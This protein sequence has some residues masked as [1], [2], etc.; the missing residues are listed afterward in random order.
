MMM[1]S[2]MQEKRLRSLN[3]NKWRRLNPQM[4]TKSDCC[5]DLIH[6]LYYIHIMS[7]VIKLFFFLLQLRFL[8]GLLRLDLCLLHSI[9]SFFL[10]LFHVFLAEMQ[11]N[12]IIFNFCTTNFASGFFLLL[13]FIANYINHLQY[14]SFSRYSFPQKLKHS[15]TPRLNLIH[16]NRCHHYR[17]LASQ[18]IFRLVLGPSPSY[19]NL[20]H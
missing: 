3:Q 6:Y 19:Q 17:G 1:T 5:I 13:L 7:S 11:Q 15:F 20:R 2:I 4:K 10:K 12:F 18:A 14:L 16:P 9:L 8:W